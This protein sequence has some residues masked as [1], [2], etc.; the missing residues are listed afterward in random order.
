MER[1]HGSQGDPRSDDKRNGPGAD[2]RQLTPQLIRLKGRTEQVS[3]DPKTKESELPY[4]FKYLLQRKTPLLRLSRALLRCSREVWWTLLQECLERFPGFRRVY[5]RG[6]LLVLSSH[7][8]FDLLARR[9]LHQPLG[10]LERAWRLLCQLVCCFSCCR[11]Q[12]LI[13]Y[14]PGNQSQL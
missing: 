8:V 7:C 14:D 6:E 5:S 3:D 11:E 1:H 2:L 10:S 13:R 4:E 12:R 9:P